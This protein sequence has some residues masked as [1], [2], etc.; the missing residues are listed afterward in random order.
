MKIK[1]YDSRQLPLNLDT[2]I[3]A[4]NKNVP[5]HKKQIETAAVIKFSTKAEQKSNS[6][7]KQL[8]VGILKGVEHIK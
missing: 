6:E 5:V 1:K 4:P 2:V 8:Y 3:L 7:L